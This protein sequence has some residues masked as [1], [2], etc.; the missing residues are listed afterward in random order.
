[1]LAPA[2]LSGVYRVTWPLF[3]V[4]SV[5]AAT[6]WTLSTGLAAYFLGPA[7]TDILRDIGVRGVIAIAIIAALGVLY[8]YLLRRRH[9]PESERGH[10]SGS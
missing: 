10:Q 7:A 5:A 1:M 9:P 6:S 2:A 4:A 8:R 3:T